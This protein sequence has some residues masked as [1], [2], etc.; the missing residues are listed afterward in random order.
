MNRAKHREGAHA[1][2]LGSSTVLETSALEEVLTLIDAHLRAVNNGCSSGSDRSAAGARGAGGARGC[3]SD[4]ASKRC[5]FLPGGFSLVDLHFAPVLERLEHIIPY[6]TEH[7]DHTGGGDGGAGAAAAAGGGGG[8]V[9]V[10]GDGS[11]SSI[12]SI[13]KQQA[14]A[15]AAVAAAVVVAAVVVVVAVVAAVVAEAAAAAVVVAGSKCSS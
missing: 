5:W 12:S 2:R 4:A 11:G 7:I 14:A 15:A 3:V 1:N 13:S 8:G 10:V 9:V 6:L